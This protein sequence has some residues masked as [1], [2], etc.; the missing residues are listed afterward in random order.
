MPRYRSRND[1]SKTRRRSR[2]E[3]ASAAISGI[4]EDVERIF[5]NLCDDD[6]VR[7]LRRYGE[8]HGS[9]ALGYAKRTYYKWKTG[10]QRVSGMIAERLLQLVPPALNTASRFELVKKLRIAHMR[11]EYR[12]LTCSGS[13]WREYVLPMVENLVATSRRFELPGHVLDR[14]TWLADGDTAIVQQLL[15]AAE[16]DEARVRLKYLDAEFARMKSLIDQVEVSTTLEQVI[17]IPQGTL[18]VSINVVKPLRAFKRATDYWAQIQKSCRRIGEL[19]AK[20]RSRTVTLVK[21][22]IE[23]EL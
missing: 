23:H 11:K 21:H 6:L 3:N 17:T 9:A 10:K 1:F 7:V 22:F 14:V 4:D 16:E 5:L 15:A 18:C 19:A 13:N 20:F 12:S 8:R 2:R